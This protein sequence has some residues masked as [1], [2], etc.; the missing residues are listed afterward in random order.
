MYLMFDD[1]VWTRL[2]VLSPPKHKLCNFKAQHISCCCLRRLMSYFA[3]YVLI[4]SFDQNAAKIIVDKRAC[5][6]YSAAVR[7]HVVRLAIATY[8]DHHHLR[9]CSE[10]QTPMLNYQTIASPPLKPPP[11]THLLGCEHLS[12]H[13][14]LQQWRPRRLPRLLP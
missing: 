8:D 3:S 10:N 11:G 14:N 5:I 12:T 1:V 7:I 4:S 2:M 13:R 9:Q 6:R